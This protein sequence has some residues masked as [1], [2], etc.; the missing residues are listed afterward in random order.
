MPQSWQGIHTNLFTVYVCV[1]VCV[2]LTLLHSLFVVKHTKLREVVVPGTELK[3]DRNLHLCV[4]VCVYVCACALSYSFSSVSLCFL[5]A[6]LHHLISIIASAAAFLHT[7][8]LTQILC[9]PSQL[10]AVV[11]LKEKCQL[12]SR[13]FSKLT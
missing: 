5:C 2:L 13:L 4:C 10:N 9:T 1:Y 11:P 8:L 12:S 7:K 3:L 6:A